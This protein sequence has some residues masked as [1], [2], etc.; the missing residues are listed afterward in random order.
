MK[1]ETLQNINPYILMLNKVINK[2]GPDPEIDSIGKNLKLT[3]EI[4]ERYYTKRQI[5][6][7]LIDKITAHQIQVAE[8]LTLIFEIQLVATQ[9]KNK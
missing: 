6:S 2:T 5:I 3:P 4:D 1:L 9:K 7:Y 8:L